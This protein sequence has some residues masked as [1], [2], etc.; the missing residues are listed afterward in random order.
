MTGACRVCH[1]DL[2]RPESRAAGIGPVC[3]EREG[4]APPRYV[5]PG[6]PRP[7][8]EDDPRQAVLDF[9]FSTA[10]AVQLD[11]PLSCP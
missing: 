8:V 9:M 4:C 6:V 10:M 11:L 5:G 2:T 3:A 7:V 1:R